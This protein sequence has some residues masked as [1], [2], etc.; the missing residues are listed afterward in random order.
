MAAALIMTDRLTLDPLRPED[1][2]DDYVR[3]QNDPDVLRYRA[4]RTS[5]SADELRRYIATLPSGDHVF[6]IRERSSA[7]HIGNVALNSVLPFHGSAEL[8][9]VIGARDSWGKGYGREAIA[10]VTEFGFGEMAL[11]RIWAESPNPAFNRIVAGLGYLHEG[12]KRQALRVGETFVDLE[13][14]GLLSSEPR[15]SGRAP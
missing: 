3:W 10:A 4:R 2:V 13:C 9:I 7:R 14:W 15:G 5:L 11:R 12:T 8:S 1:V 6:A